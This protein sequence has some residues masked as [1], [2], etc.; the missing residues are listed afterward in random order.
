MLA[1]TNENFKVHVAVNL[2]SWI[3]CFLNIPMS[4]RGFCSS[5]S[6]EKRVG[7]S[8]FMN[9]TS[10][11]KIKRKAKTEHGKIHT[12]HDPSRVFDLQK[13]FHCL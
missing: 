6:Q 11:V 5:N 8:P 1:W 10:V 12:K 7:I 4:L 13:H 9:Q 3:G 2:E